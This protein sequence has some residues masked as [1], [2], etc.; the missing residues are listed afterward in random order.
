MRLLISKG[1]TLFELIISAAIISVISIIGVASYQSLIANQA[2]SYRADQIYY[3]LKFAQS[4]AI[5]R[6]TK[7][8]VHFCEQQSVWK[9]GISES[10]QC[11]CFTS[12]A[13]QLD[14]VEKV[15]DLADGKR[16]LINEDDITFTNNQ[17]SYGVLR[18]SVEIGSLTLTNSENKSLSIIQSAARLR[19]CAPDNNKLGYPPC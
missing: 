11:D 17:A 3:T 13:C 15:Q 8:Y 12:H 7:I 4:E 14:G 16:L 9:M 6:N 19:V 2:L 18:F 1:F 5:K 10:P